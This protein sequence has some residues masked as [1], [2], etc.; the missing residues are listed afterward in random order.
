M[1]SLKVYENAMIE[2]EIN[3]IVDTKLQFNDLVIKYLD[4]SNIIV[5]SYDTTPED[6]LYIYSVIKRG[7]PVSFKC[8][9]YD[10]RLNIYEPINME[11]A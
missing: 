7:Q 10:A 11:L 4:E 1:N 5:I 8:S 3:T 9:F 2:V 6:V